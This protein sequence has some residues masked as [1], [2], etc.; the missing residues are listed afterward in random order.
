[1]SNLTH[2]KGNFFLL[3]C[4]LNERWSQ[5]FNRIGLKYQKQYFIKKL[6]TKISWNAS[7]KKQMQFN[8]LKTKKIF[9]Y[10]DIT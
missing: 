2:L 10:F 3:V 4:T 1:M 8:I 7:L 6:T 5:I 9:L